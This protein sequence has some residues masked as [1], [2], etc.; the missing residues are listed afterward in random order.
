MLLALAGLEE[1]CASRTEAFAS[2]GVMS[3]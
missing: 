1:A 2:A 3:F